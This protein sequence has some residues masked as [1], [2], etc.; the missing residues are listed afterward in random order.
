MGV[1][2]GD[3]KVKI[4]TAFQDTVTRFPRLIELLCYAETMARSRTP[5]LITGES[6]TGKG[7]LARGIH[8]ASKRPEGPFITVNVASVPESLFEG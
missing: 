5:F 6:G 7:V 8:R 3:N 1:G 4:P 2:A